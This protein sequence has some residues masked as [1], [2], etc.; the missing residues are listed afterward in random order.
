MSW[1]GAGI[2]TGIGFAVGGPIG[3]AIGMVVGS[4]L[5]G[6][7]RNSS[8]AQQN[9]MLFFV[10]LFSMLSKMARADGKIVKKEIQAVTEF[11]DSMRLDE[12]DKRAAIEIFRNVESDGY[13]IYEYASQYKEVASPEMC[14]MIYSALWL[15]AYSDGVIQVEEDEILQNI[16]QYL[17]LGSN[18]YTHFK[19]RVMGNQPDSGNLEE[20]YEVLG[21]NKNDDDS[22]IKSAYRRA[23]KEYHPDKMQSKG[24]P[25]E[26]LQFANE[27]TKKLNK[28]YSAI[29]KSRGMK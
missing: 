18:S 15:V 10:S 8:T 9:Q 20:H 23:V 19:Q 22:T 14:E 7:S 27:Q 29:K 5:G 2:F 6:E 3:G 12:E 16:V 17:G 11:M 1:L 13:S 21:V 26:F 4:L 25:K 24:L 28:A